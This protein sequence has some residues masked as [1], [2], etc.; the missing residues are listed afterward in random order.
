VRFN[1]LEEW[2]EAV[3]TAVFW[4]SLA[5]YYYF[6]TIGSWGL[7]HDEVHLEHVQEMPIAFPEKAELRERIVKIV[8][9]LQT[10]DIG[11][12][13]SLFGSAQALN[14]LP[15]LERQLDDAVFDLYMLSP[16]ERDLIREMCDTGL[17]LF[18]R[19]ENSEALRTVDRPQ[20]DAGTIATLRQADDGLP[21]YLR[22][23]LKIW[24]AE[25]EAD[26]EFRW[27]VLSPPSGAPLIAVSFTA[28][29]KSDAVSQLSSDEAQAWREVLATLDRVSLSP[30]ERSRIFMDSFFRYVSDTEILFIKRNERRFWSR[31]AARE[32]AE[33]ALTFMMNSHAADV[34]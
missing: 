25:L 6:T 31:T 24:N 7:W 12:N 8:T 5:R 28:Q 32:D 17:D 18:Y 30:V 1:G 13:N 22:T 9:Q 23:F 27:H 26:S 4:S 19:K 2:Q 14:Q 11:S 33:S 10:L 16:G 21:S 29:Y 3:I 34:A 15:E 20:Q